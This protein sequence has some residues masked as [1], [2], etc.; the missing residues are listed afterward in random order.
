MDFFFLSTLIKFAEIL[1]YWKLYILLMVWLFPQVILLNIFTEREDPGN[2][3]NPE[4]DFKDVEYILF[5]VV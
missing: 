4:T 1:A 5:V 2:S 3:S